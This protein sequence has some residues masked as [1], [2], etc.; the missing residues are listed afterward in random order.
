MREP[1]IR[2]LDHDV[3][4]RAAERMARWY[5]GDRGWGAKLV[6]AYLWPR[7]TNEALDR[8]EGITPSPVYPTH[9]EQDR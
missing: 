8:E 4:I 5:L 6:G 7:A 9:Q 2:P 3:R 1:D